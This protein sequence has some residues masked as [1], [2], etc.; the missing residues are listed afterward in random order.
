[1]LKSSMSI[2]LMASATGASLMV[3]EG[4]DSASGPLGPS[5][6]RAS[7]THPRWQ[8][9]DFTY[10]PPDQAV[11]DTTPFLSFLLVNE[12]HGSWVTC[13]ASRQDVDYASRNKMGALNC[14]MPQTFFRFDSKS[15]SLTV[16]Q[17]WG[18]S[19]LKL[20]KYDTPLSGLSTVS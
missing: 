10:F 13:D 15:G 20:R 8:I 2:I 19:D 17:T 5:C 9:K 1:M 18:C 16:Q 12:A 7:F 3:R 4:L 11:N 14:H 6:A